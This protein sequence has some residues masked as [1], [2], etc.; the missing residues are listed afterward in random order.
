MNP[1][2]IIALTPLW[3]G[4]IAV[5]VGLPVGLY[6]AK[7]ERAEREARAAAEAAAS[8]VYRA[9]TILSAASN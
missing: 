6:F 1:D 8:Q 4:I 9:S 2:I 5:V 3:L 7:R